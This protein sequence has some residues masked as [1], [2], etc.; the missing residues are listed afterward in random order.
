MDGLPGRATAAFQRR[1]SQFISERPEHCH[2]GSQ[3]GIMTR[4][5]WL[6]RISLVWCAALVGALL[7]LLIAP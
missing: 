4:D 6:F 1:V 5:T 2:V 3:E 7:F